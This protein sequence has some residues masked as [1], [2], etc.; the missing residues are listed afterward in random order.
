[1]IEYGGK[2]VFYKKLDTELVEYTIHTV[3][4]YGM[5]PI[6]EGREYLYMDDNEFGKD[7]MCIR[8]SSKGVQQESHIYQ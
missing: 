2:T 3:R 5:R 7:K 8:D 4:K 1:M 6:L